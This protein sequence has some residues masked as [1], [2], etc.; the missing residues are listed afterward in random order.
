MCVCVCV[1]VCVN[2]Q[3]VCNIFIY[4]FLH[5]CTYLST[6][7]AGD[8]DHIDCI[9]AMKYIPTEESPGYHTEESNGESTNQG[10]HFPCNY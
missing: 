3:V 2:K 4:I 7:S 9:Y 8:V 5:V 6:K 10:V 1:C